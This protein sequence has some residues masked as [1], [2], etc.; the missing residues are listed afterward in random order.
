MD[1]QLARRDCGLRPR[2]CWAVASWAVAS[3]QIQWKVLSLLFIKGVGWGLGSGW[4]L[5]FR[6]SNLVST[7]S[8]T[9]R[10]A[11]RGAGAK[12]GGFTMGTDMAW[13]TLA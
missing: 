3:R 8:R 9:Q 12:G 11:F 4:P 10:Q 5:G 6:D 2:V 13:V 7:V 1:A